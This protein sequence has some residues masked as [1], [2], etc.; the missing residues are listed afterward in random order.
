MATEKW[1]E[2]KEIRQL[3]DRISKNDGLSEEQRIR[4]FWQSY[5]QKIRP[6]MEAE[7]R[8]MVESRAKLFTKGIA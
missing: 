7:D 5:C 6:L 3:I 8:F 2:R 4:K 1:E